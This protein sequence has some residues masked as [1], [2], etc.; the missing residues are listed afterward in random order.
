MDLK[1]FNVVVY[2]MVNDHKLQCKTY[3]WIR[4]C[5]FTPLQYDIYDGINQVGYF[6][7]RHGYLEVYYPS[8]DDPCEL[9]YDK[10]YPEKSPYD[11]SYGFK[12]DNDVSITEFFKIVKE[13]TTLI[14]EK[15][16]SRDFDGK[17]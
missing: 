14:H 2:D 10:D 9:I 1:N 16:K 7:C 6:K 11:L 12:L 8:C 13:V 5:N 15:I 4:T 17:P 3:D